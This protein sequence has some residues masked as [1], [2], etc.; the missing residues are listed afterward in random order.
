MNNKVFSSSFIFSLILFLCSAHISYSADVKEQTDHQLLNNEAISPSQVSQSTAQEKEGPEKTIVFRYDGENLVDIINFLAAKKEVNIVLPQMA[1]AINSKVT[2]R[3]EDKLSLDEAWNLLITILDIA[4]FSL[5]PK[6][7][8]FSIVKK[9]PNTSKEPLPIYIGTK[10][11]DLPDT[12]TYIRYLYYLTNIKVKELEKELEPVL[13]ELLPNAP[14]K[15]EPTSNALLIIAKANDIKSVMKII[16]E[17]DQTGFQEKFEVITLRYANAKIV[18]DLFTEKILKAATAPQRYGVDTKKPTEAMF[19]SKHTRVLPETRTNSL[20][21]LGRAQA[22]DRIKEFI[23]KYID[24]ELESGKSILHIYEVLYL[25]AGDLADVLK[26]IIESARSGGTGQAAGGEAQG[27]ERS[28][29]PEPKIMADTPKGDSSKYSGGNKLIVA[30]SNDDWKVIRKLIEDLDKPEPQVLIEVLIADLTLEDIRL[31]GASLRNP[32]KIPLP[33]DVNYQSAHIGGILLDDNTNPTP[34]KADLLRKAFNATGGSGSDF[35]QA[36]LL[37]PG[38]TV[39]SLSDS[40]GKTWGIAQIL[41]TFRNT[42]ILSHP[43]VIAINNK[44]AIIN[45]GESRL[46]RDE[47]SGSTGGTTTLKRK[48]ESA[49]LTVTITP[50]ISTA[51]TVNLQVKVNINEFVSRATDSRVTRLVETNANVFSKDI[52]AI[53][54]LIKMDTQHELTETPILGKIPILGWFFKKRRNRANKTS[55]TVFIMPTIIEPR[56]RGGIGEYT[57]DYIRVAKDYA[58]EGD[59]FEGLKDPV[60]RWFFKTGT[61]AAEIIDDFLAKDKFKANA[62][63]TKA[64]QNNKPNK[65]S[66]KK[67]KNIEYA[68]TEQQTEQLKKLIAQEESPLLRF[69]QG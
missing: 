9:S 16:L 1:N 11:D 35:S 60:T 21:I 33:N 41:K 14:F 12:D 2:I 38:S 56:L 42:K 67:K 6:E 59:L 31:L 10:P 26:K 69:Q 48:M 55:L 66:N 46:L 17:L 30:A 3:I 22:V 68:A 61:D 13:K 40:D 18:A 45:I 37:T 7:N 8:T 19:F 20:I 5:I 34:L 51:N 24:V 43:H 52:L 23:F 64:S 27:A 58:F 28:F 57:Q 15:V 44:E 47:A 32:C 29:D 49:D 54:G 39:F 62:K 65:H 63:Q 36:S 50:R 53:G 4:G 25:N